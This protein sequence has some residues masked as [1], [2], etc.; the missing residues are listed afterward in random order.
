MVRSFWLSLLLGVGLVLG[1]APSRAQTVRLPKTGDPAFSVDV[2]TGWTYDYDQNNNLQF[3]S[4]DHSTALQLSMIV[5]P[6]VGTTPL[7]SVATDVFKSAGA[8]PYSKNE[9]GTLAGHAGEAFYGNLIINNNLLHMTLVLAK[10]D[11]SHVAC[12]TTITRD[13]ATPE[14]L[15]TLNALIGLV[16]LSGT[17]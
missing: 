13:G 7:S 9:P 1:S 11:N 14:Q 16:R 3:L 15:A 2:P 10:L 6:A 8:E 17:Q 4:G 5:D 12:L